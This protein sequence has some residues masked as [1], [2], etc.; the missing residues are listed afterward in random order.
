MNFLFTPNKT[1]ASMISNALSSLTT[2]LENLKLGI[3]QGLQ[4]AND[5]QVTIDDLTTEKTK[6]QASVED[7]STVHANL[8][9][10]LGK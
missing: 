5:M 4:E 10:L 8:S 6:I 9:N 3:D 2:T 7:A 1:S